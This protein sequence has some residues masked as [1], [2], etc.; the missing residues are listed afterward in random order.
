[1]A[2]LEK[3]LDELAGEIDGVLSSGIVR[4]SDGQPVLGRSTDPAFAPDLA[5]YA[6]VMRLHAET[7]ERMGGR[8]TLGGTEDF[9]ISMEKTCLLIRMLGPDHFFALLLARPATNPALARFVM[10]R[11]EPLFQVA[12]RG[13]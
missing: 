6:A 8:E 4:L 7:A 12:L 13:V 9:L 3:L 10:Q 11:Y 5:A 2:D 1:M